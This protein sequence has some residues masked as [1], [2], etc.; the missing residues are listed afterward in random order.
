MKTRRTPQPRSRRPQCLCFSF[1][2][3]WGGGRIKGKLFTIIHLGAQPTL[4]RCFASSFGFTLLVLYIY[5]SQVHIEV[6]YA[7]W[8]MEIA[9]SASQRRLE[10]VILL[11]PPTSA[12]KF[13]T[14]W[15]K[16][17]KIICPGRGGWRNFAVLSQMCSWRHNSVCLSQV[18][19]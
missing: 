11:E 18:S 14:Q 16:S 10:A 12:Q 9:S 3:F 15:L 17:A 4:P 7:K 6:F 19:V 1:N 2:F 5:M 8:L 13:S